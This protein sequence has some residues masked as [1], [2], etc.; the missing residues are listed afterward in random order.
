MEG[1]ARGD[2]GQWLDV[3]TLDLPWSFPH[4]AFPNDGAGVWA[5]FERGKDKKW[6]KNSRI[7]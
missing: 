1:T 5:S 2:S 6:I 7:M 3:G 4:L